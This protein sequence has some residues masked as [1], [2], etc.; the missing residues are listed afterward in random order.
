MIIQ[1]AYAL[2]AVVGPALWA[3]KSAIVALYIRLFAVERWLKVT[4]YITIAVLFLVYCSLVPIASVFC[5]PQHGGPW[6]T[7]V[8]ARCSD[9]LRFEGPLQGAVAIAADVFI[10]CLPL[11]VLRK[12]NLPIRKKASLGVVFLVGI[13]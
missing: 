12:L 13:L 7:M 8:L 3:A 10:L 5:T 1:R 9:K 4:S 6:D 11:P 2:N